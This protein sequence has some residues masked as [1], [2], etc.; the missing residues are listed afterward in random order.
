MPD[1]SL[2]LHQRNY[3]IKTDGTETADE[4]F[5]FNNGTIERYFKGF[6][7]SAEEP[8]K[9]TAQ[10][11]FEFEDGQ[12]SQCDVNYVDNIDGEQ[13]SSKQYLFN[14]KGKISACAVDYKEEKNGSISAKT[15]FN[16]KNGRLSQIKTKYQA[17]PKNHIATAQKNFTLDDYVN[18]IKSCEINNTGLTTDNFDI[19]NLNAQKIANYSRNWGY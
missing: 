9:T 5:I 4:F 12:I 2:Y 3:S 15:V 18:H 16:Y 1:G 8:L 7:D 17:Y 11:M 14:K 6:F 10:K 13:T 19:H